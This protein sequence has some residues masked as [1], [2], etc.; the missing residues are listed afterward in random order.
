MAN[1][2][3]LLKNTSN[4]LTRI[5]QAN[6][7]YDSKNLKCIFKYDNIEGQIIDKYLRTKPNIELKVRI[8]YVF[9]LSQTK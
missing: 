2:D 8:L 3:Y 5:V 7:S 4:D 6:F 1:F 9:P